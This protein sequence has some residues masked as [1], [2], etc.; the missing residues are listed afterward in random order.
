M[1]IDKEEIFIKKKKNTKIL[2]I[3]MKWCVY[4]II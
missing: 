4:N 3:L 1:A 2:D